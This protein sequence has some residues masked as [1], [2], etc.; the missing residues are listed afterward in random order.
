MSR[1]LLVILGNQL[2][3]PP[4][5]PVETN[6]PVFMAEDAGLCTYVRHHQHKLVLLLAA[7]RSYRDELRAAGYRVIYRDLNTPG[8]YE[9]KLLEA[10]RDTGCGQLLHFEIEGKTM[11][12][13]MQ[14]FGVR[15]SLQQRV[16]PS[17]MFLCSR[18]DFTQTLSAGQRPRMASFYSAQ[19]KRLGVL[20][21]AD[22]KPMGGQWS[23]DADNRKKLPRHVQPPELAAAPPGA[24]VADVQRIVSNHFASHPGRA[25]D[26][27]LPTTRAQAHEW[28][29]QFLEQRFASFGPYEDA[30]TQRSDSLF[31][32]VL[33][34]LLNI[35]LLTP[36]EVLGR[37]LEHARD[38]HI[39]LNSL[40]GFVRQI[41]GW[42]EFIRGIYN[43]F[44]G[45]QS[46]RN[47]WGHQREL[48]RHWSDGST[49]IPPLDDAID[50]ALRLGW[51]HHIPR[52]M[53]LGNMMTLCE[54]KPT[55]AHRWFMEMFVDSANWVMG[56]N[57]Y[58]MG[59]FSDGGIFATKPYICGSNYL[60][61]MSDYAKGTWC[62]VVD[63]LYWR[64]VDKHMDF[65]TANPRLA[66]I[67]R[68]AARLAPE[69]RA[70][71]AKAAESFL[72]TRT[73]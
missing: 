18:P 59:L 37:A 43:N 26:F 63:G 4:E 50:A 15:H 60:L 7:M 58:G 51:T 10:C 40:E 68:G 8:Q 24:H 45:E 55:S 70:R 16:L 28:L 17:P 62:D 72:K 46:S 48:T 56:P 38:H 32:S 64:F 29:Q 11:E 23:F 71:I 9:D 73:R 33:S 69:R 5:L 66:V 34:P 1:T 36:A 25:E 21:D 35:G 13:R 53:V 14:R 20:L 49:G 65:F 39:P 61:K 57:V 2:F 31:H 44:S 42:R 3:P 47:F 54:I 52:L 19:R 27:W 22:G 30:L 67:A 41:I 12:R 6:T